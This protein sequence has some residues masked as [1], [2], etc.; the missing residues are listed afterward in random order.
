MQ[1]FYFYPFSHGISGSISEI[2]YLIIKQNQIISYFE[3]NLEQRIRNCAI[4]K[5]FWRNWDV[6]YRSCFAYKV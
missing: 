2:N 4:K 1:F 5:I 6:K 3:T